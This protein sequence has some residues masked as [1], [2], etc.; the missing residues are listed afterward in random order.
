MAG[1]VE[2]TF[3]TQWCERDKSGALRDYAQ[4]FRFDELPAARR[5]HRDA[6]AGGWMLEGYSAGHVSELRT[7]KDGRLLREELADAVDVP[8]VADR[9]RVA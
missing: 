7:R 9:R 3:V 1:E 2:F 5:A 6:C 8:A 4:F